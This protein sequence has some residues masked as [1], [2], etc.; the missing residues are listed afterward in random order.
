VVPSYYT[1]KQ[2]LNI[3]PSY[4]ELR[5]TVNSRQPLSDVSKEIA[6][7]TDPA[8]VI[9]LLFEVRDVVVWGGCW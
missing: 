1:V 2:A 5:K 9:Q 7:A 8:L 4:I 3:L 6:S